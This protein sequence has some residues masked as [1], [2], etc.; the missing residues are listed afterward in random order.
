MRGCAVDAHGEGM[1]TV[2]DRAQ[3]GRVSVNKYDLFHTSASTA[4]FY[5]VFHAFFLSDF[6][7]HIKMLLGQASPAKVIRVFVRIMD[8]IQLDLQRRLHSYKV[9][10]RFAVQPLLC[11]ESLTTTESTRVKLFPHNS[12]M[13]QS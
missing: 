4:R 8:R 3:S 5:Q 12:K 11:Q 9:K 7:S 10:L 2:G 1:V 6:R 13:S